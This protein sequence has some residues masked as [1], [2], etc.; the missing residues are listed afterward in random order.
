MCNYDEY[1]SLNGIGFIVV[2]VEIF[3]YI[4]YFETVFFI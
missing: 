2:V 1:L 3:K 4:I